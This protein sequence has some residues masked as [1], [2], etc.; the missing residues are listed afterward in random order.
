M[1]RLIPE[2]ERKHREAVAVAQQ[3][4]RD[5]VVERE[6]RERAE[7]ALREIAERRVPKQ[8][9]S[10]VLDIEAFARSALAQEQESA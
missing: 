4:H 1:S 10:Y 2:L 9:I 8:T 7:A 3:A 5:L 6:A